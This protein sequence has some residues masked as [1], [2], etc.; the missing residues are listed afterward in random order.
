M[1]SFAYTCALSDLPIEAGDECRIIPM[2][3]S[4]QGLNGGACSRMELVF[5]GVKGTYDDYGYVEDLNPTPFQEK[6]AGLMGYSSVSD[7]VDNLKEGNVTVAGRGGEGMPVVFSL[8]REDAW[9]AMRSMPGELHDSAYENQDAEPFMARA[10]QEGGAFFALAKE[11]L[12]QDKLGANI[13]ETIAAKRVQ[14]GA[15]PEETAKMQAKILMDYGMRDELVKHPAFKS[16]FG[17]YLDSSYSA[18]YKGLDMGSVLTMWSLGGASQTELRDALMEAGEQVLVNMNMNT[19]R[20][21]WLERDS[22]GPQCGE[23][24]LHWLWARKLGEISKAQVDWTDDDAANYMSGF[25]EAKSIMLS[26]ELKREVPE[27]KKASGPKGL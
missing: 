7:F 4:F 8:V 12:E 5:P 17:Y 9:Q 23:H 6:L 24:A 18:I 1:G 27:A 26:D 13:V 21:V 16:V 19:I 14:E 2:C 20:K 3:N 25:K 22:S 10:C 11:V 15:G